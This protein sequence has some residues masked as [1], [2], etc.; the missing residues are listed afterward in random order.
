M[1]NLVSIVGIKDDR[2]YRGSADI[3]GFQV[4]YCVYCIFDNQ[5]SYAI[6]D[7]KVWWNARPT[8]DD[9][10]LNGLIPIGLDNICYA[11]TPTALSEK[12]KGIVLEAIADWVRNHAL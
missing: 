4:A 6:T 8:I 5:Q 2:A 10:L 9:E 12:R 11:L 3:P 1:G 7:G